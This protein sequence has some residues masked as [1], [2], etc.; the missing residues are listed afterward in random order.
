MLVR[1]HVGL[2][3]GT[4]QDI[5]PEAAR[6]M[7]ADGRASLPNYGQEATVQ[8]VATVNVPHTETAKIT[9]KRRR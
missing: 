3:A 7:V 8:E 2:R 5:C 6:A 9:L 4:I 1:V